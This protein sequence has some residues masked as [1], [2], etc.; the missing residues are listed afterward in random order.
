MSDKPKYRNQN[1][2]IS[3]NVLGV[4]SQDMQFIYALPG[5]EGSANDGR[6]LRDAIRRTNSLRVPH[7]YYYLIDVRYTN[8]TGFLAPFQSD[9]HEANE[10]I[11]SVEPSNEWSAM[12]MTLAGHMYNEWRHRS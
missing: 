10:S 4:C 12:R 1:G 5:W 3:T 7:G 8:C 11:T 2:D 9:D 6:V